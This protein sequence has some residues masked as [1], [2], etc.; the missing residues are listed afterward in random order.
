MVPQEIGHEWGM[1]WIDPA[2][3]RKKL[4]IVMKTEKSNRV[5]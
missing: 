5:S 3:E 2:P 1:D 4:S